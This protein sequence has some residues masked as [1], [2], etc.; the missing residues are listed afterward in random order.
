MIKKNFKKIK[1]HGAAVIIG[2]FVFVICFL[3]YYFGVLDQLEYRA[4][5]F[6]V[7]SL[8]E[9]T[10]PSDDIMIVVVDQDSID[11]AQQERSWSWP[12]PRRSFGEIVEY[13]DRAGAA[14]V[15][16]DIIYSE[17]SV[18]GPEDDQYFA[19][20]SADYGRVV[21]TVF[22]SSQTGN[23]NTWPNNI[24][25]PMFKLNNFETIIKS[26]SLNTDDSA[27]RMGAQ[28]PISQIAAS[29]GVIGNIT[30]RPDS[31]NVY[32]RLP[33][34]LDFDN[35]AVP[36]LSTAGLLASGWNADIRY[37][38]N[39]KNISWEDYTIPVDK[40]GQAILRFRGDMNRYI[41][42]SAAQILQSNEVLLDGREP[43]LSP[44]NFEGKHVFVGL[45]A[46]GLFD[47]CTT[48][49][50]S[51]YPGMGMHITMLD[52]ML[53]QDFIQEPPLWFS[54]LLIFVISALVCLLTLYSKRIVFGIIGLVLIFLIIIGGTIA[55]Y[56][57][58]YW[59]PMVAPLFAA[60]LC[61][62]A[63]TVYN[64]ATEGSQRK[65]IK[66]AFGQYL[67]PV[68]IEKLI[69]NPELLKLGGER[70]EL[71]VFFSDIQG[72]TSISE[73]MEPTQLTEFM[74]K[75]LS[76]ITNIIQDSGG[77]VDKYIGDAVVAFWNAPLDQD[78]HAAQAL[79]SALESQRQLKEQNEVYLQEYGFKLLTRIGINTGDIVVGNFGSEKRFNYSMLGDAV[80]LGA[81][82]EGLNKQFGT[83]IMCTKFSFDKA[84]Q[85]QT[86][87]GRKL[88]KVAVVGKAEAVPVVEPMLKETFESKK[89]VIEKF[90]IG[91]DF[92][93]DGKFSEA[94]K[95]FETIIDVDPP[96]KYYAEQCRYFMS[97]PSKWKGYWIAEGK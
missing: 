79:Y 62:I 39:K 19:R 70:R 6:R 49:I 74:N 1:K 7:V 23:T 54:V 80:N 29:A 32:R 30:G 40:N 53:Q 4:Y 47:I 12:W 83:Y 93:Y 50:S 89:E 90:E 84:N 42:Y 37:D 21:Q 17:P 97:N 48:P 61:F 46:P 95:I 13:M 44:E 2:L 22:F 43:L 33:L 20:A 92:F 45:Y 72:F 38:Q 86:F 24:V 31:D 36:G 65:F 10:R 63:G 67:S 16:F 94:L 69:A 82:L 26:L 14:S 51:A 8:A 68:F 64:Y 59:V 88:A 75:Y 91:Y 78:D 58:G 76:F 41:P 28:F 25:T 35:K 34:F 9:S 18:Y 73:K 87:Y 5:D 27:E 96:A 81:R 3:A 77:Y 57:A 66:S 85:H 55:A 60:A 71:S 52:N 56:V 15:I 11:W